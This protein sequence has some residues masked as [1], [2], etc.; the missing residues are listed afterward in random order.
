MR[1]LFFPVLICLLLTGC[2][3][4]RQA[5]PAEAVSSQPVQSMGYYQPD[6]D[7]EQATGCVR[8]YPL[9]NHTDAQI[10]IWGEDVLLFS[11]VEGGTMLTRL[12]GSN[13]YAAASRTL[14]ISLRSD[15]PAVFITGDH[16][17]YPGNQELICLDRELQEVDRIPFPSGADNTPLLTPDERLLYYRAG[18]AI[19]E[20]D[21]GSGVNRIVR[22]NGN[23][24]ISLRALHF[25]GQVLE[26]VTDGST[27]F[28]N[29]ADGTVLGKSQDIQ[30]FSSSQWYFARIRD[31]ITRPCLF[32][33][34][35]E[36]PS[37]LEIS[38]ENCWFLP[39]I[40]GV[41]AVDSVAG[42]HA[43]TL[44][45]LS[46]GRCS[47]SLSL[48]ISHPINQIQAADLQHVYILTR[49]E[50]QF[51]LYC[52]DSQQAPAPAEGSAAAPFHSRENPDLTGLQDC[53]SQA[54]QIGTRYGVEILIHE[55]AAALS[56]LAYDLEPEHLV[57]VLSHQL[58]RVEAC[59]SQF[60][61]EVLQ[62]LTDHFGGIT[63]LLVRQVRGSPESGNLQSLTGAL[64]WE[65]GRVYVAIPAGDAVD[66]ALYSQLYQ[67]MDTIILN[68]SVALDQ[69]EALNP[70]GFQY[71]FGQSTE[72]VSEEYLRG[73]TMAFANRQAMHSPKEDRG[74]VMALAMMPNNSE[75]FSAA[76]MQRK[77]QALCTGIRQAFGLR[78]S[79]EI[80]PWEQYLVQSMAYT[81]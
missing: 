37:L 7:I 79:P 70:S 19:R 27:L 34:A 8:T 62:T 31:G 71:A 59:L 63:L 41:A 14:D 77:L 50:Q 67:L 51:V 13:L 75:V 29:A 1:S 55:E 20:L 26:C 48:P 18:T 80:F 73:E 32:G 49:Q 23:T 22:E 43:I 16:L 78:K 40:H 33:R 76:I 66:Y 68:K 61:R 15:D 3:L 30:F 45:D 53:R 54:E 10:E 17:W 65:N 42:A 21:L 74:A 35:V 28:L 58:D 5:E 25:D 24:T 6:S 2:A 36:S 56:P 81:G 12:S 46:T 11:E 52:W 47:A 44:Y 60:P 4:P 57:D 38:G 69:W 39:A 64:F 9:E 72:D